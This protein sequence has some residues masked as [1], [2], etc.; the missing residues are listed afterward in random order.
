[1]VKDEPRRPL[2]SSAKN[3]QRERD[4]GNAGAGGG[5]QPRGCLGDKIIPLHEG[6]SC[7]ISPGWGEEGGEPGASTQ[8]PQI[9]LEKG[10]KTMRGRSSRGTGAG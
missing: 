10:K 6:Q 7:R 4:C 5:E 1:M 9:H 2:P 3:E 8:H